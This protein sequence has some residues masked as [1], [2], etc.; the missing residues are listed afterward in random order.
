M[1]QLPFLCTDFGEIHYITIITLVVAPLR[2]LITVV[3]AVI[4]A[5]KVR[6]AT[7]NIFVVVVVCLLLFLGVAKGM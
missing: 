1:M 2:M 7:G 5:M 3:V 4:V 6:K